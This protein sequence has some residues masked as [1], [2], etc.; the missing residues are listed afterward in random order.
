MHYSKRPTYA[1]AIAAIRWMGG[2]D[3]SFTYGELCD[4]RDTTALTRCPDWFPT[5]HLTYEN[6]DEFKL[7][8][9]THPEFPVGNAIQVGED[10]WI[11]NTPGNFLQL[12]P[13]QWLIRRRCE[14]PSLRHL[15]DQGYMP[16]FSVMDDEVF[17][18]HYQPAKL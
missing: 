15:M 8:F 3:G 1:E 10:L 5:L 18:R 17:R 4:L 14:D 11:R 6:V 9:L 12:K 13:G 2:E 7:H 16:R